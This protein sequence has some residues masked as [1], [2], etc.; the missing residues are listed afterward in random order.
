MGVNDLW[1]Q[2]TPILFTCKEHG[3]WIEW[4]TGPLREWQLL[5]RDRDTVELNDEIVYSLKFDCG[6]WDCINGWRTRG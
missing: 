3:E 5:A 2:K 6:E 1:E 4:V